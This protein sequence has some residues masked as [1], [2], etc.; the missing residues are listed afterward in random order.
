V[1]AAVCSSALP[2]CCSR[3]WERRCN[4]ALSCSSA[5]PCCCSRA[6]ERRCNRALSWTPRLPRR[7]CGGLLAAA[8]PT[9]AQPHWRELV[10]SAD[11]HQSDPLLLPRWHTLTAGQAPQGMAALP[12]SAVALLSAQPFLRFHHVDY[13]KTESSD[14]PAVKKLL[15]TVQKQLKKIQGR[16]RHTYGHQSMTQ[17][18]SHAHDVGQCSAP[19]PQ[20]EPITDH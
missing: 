6:W 19:S 4:R 17:V 14:Y 13:A 3:A 11:G 18:I 7:S 2:C 1:A 9:P 20:R 5:L 15:V 12:R 8:V 16:I 10:E